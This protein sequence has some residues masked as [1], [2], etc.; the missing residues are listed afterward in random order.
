MINHRFRFNYKMSCNH[1]QE[2]KVKNSA[3]SSSGS[4]LSGV[5]TGNCVYSK[6]KENI[7]EDSHENNQTDSTSGKIAKFVRIE[8]IKLFIYFSNL[9]NYIIGHTC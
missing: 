1:G 2:T 4:V 3:P 5:V 9:N 8:Y 6:T 7:V